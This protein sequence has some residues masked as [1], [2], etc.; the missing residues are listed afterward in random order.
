MPLLCLFLIPGLDDVMKAKGQRVAL[1]A[2]LAWSATV[3]CIG[4]FT[5]DK[6]WNDRQIFVARLPSAAKPFS[7]LTEDEAQEFAAKNRGLFIGPYYC[8]IDFTYCRHRL[9][10]FAD[11]EI[12]YYVKNFRV[13]RDRRARMTL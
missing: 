9:W 7:F 13:T 8:N 12:L 11:N 4:A 1:Y 2:T 10:S 6:S 3:Q 5:Y